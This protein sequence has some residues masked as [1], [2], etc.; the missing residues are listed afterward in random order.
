M[1]FKKRLATATII[2]CVFFLGFSLNAFAG[3]QKYEEKF[4]ET[5][6]LVKSG[7]VVLTNIS[8]DIDVKT[9]NRSE[10]EI[11]AKK[12]S[13]ASSMEKAK[14]HADKV[15]IEIEKKG[16]VLYIKT[17]YPKIS[18]NVFNVSVDFNLMI[19]EG[20]SASMKSVSGDIFMKKIGGKANANSVSGDIVM[21]SITGSLVANAVSGDIEVLRAG[22]GVECESVSGELTL[23][24]ITG[25]A[26]LKAVSGDI[27]VAGLKG[28]VEA[29]S[30]SGDIKVMGV[31]DASTVTVKV[32]SGDVD[33]AGDIYADGRYTFKSHSGDVILVLPADAAFDLEAKTF[34]GTIDSAF[35]IMVMGKLSKREIRG[36]VNNGGAAVT[37]GTFSGDVHLKKK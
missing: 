15:T 1:R 8:G 3:K 12:I 28:S 6:A 5:I 18:S 24:D 20:A 37:V 26:Y 32:L 13:K 27:T 17:E 21:E 31:S 2:A 30:V 29:D 7:K 10:V 4:N 23:E 34:S 35:E 11:D 25:N 9:W 36:S 14:E 19:P 16:D 22:S 33:Y